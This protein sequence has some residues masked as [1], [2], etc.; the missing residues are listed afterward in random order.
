M[1]SIWGVWAG[2]I[3]I[4]TQRRQYEGRNTSLGYIVH[5]QKEPEVFLPKY[6]Q[7]AILHAA[8]FQGVVIK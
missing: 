6:S 2:S 1:G 3:N 4:E 5:G 7:T 8:H